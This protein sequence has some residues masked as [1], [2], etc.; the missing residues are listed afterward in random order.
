MRPKSSKII[1][2]EIMKKFLTHSPYGPLDTWKQRQ[3]THTQKETNYT[4]GITLASFKL[5]LR[6][7]GAIE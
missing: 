6:I 7:E 3:A 4:T 1:V 5:S 2:T